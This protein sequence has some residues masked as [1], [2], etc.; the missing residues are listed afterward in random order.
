M[1]FEVSLHEIDLACRKNR[2]GMGTWGRP[3][4]TMKRLESWSTAPKVKG[5]VLLEV[6]F[7]VISIRKLRG[8]SGKALENG[9]NCRNSV[10]N[11][12]KMGITSEIP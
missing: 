2:F 7:P 5:L 6:F 4:K 8:K 1:T 3:I 9:L 12:Y 10:R 11:L